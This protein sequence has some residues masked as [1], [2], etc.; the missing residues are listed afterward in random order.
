MMK[1]VRGRDFLESG[2]CH[3]LLLAS[4][5]LKS[6]APESCANVS[7]TFGRGCTSRSTFPFRGF[8]SMHIRSAPSF[9]GT[10]TMPAHHGVGSSAL[11]MTPRDSIRSS[12]SWTLGRRVSGESRSLPLRKFPSPWN[13]VG[14][15]F[16]MSVLVPKVGAG[17]S[18]SVVST[19]MAN[20][21]AV[22]AGRPRRFVL[23]PST[24]FPLFKSFPQNCP[25]VF[26]GFLWS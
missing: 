19:R 2:I 14:N 21:R 24:S 18:V 6:L 10:T 20:P 5:L 4:N 9:S 16:M 1:V 12:S 13:T 8:R 11:E 25:R 7:P 15:R 23:R 22:I 17:K 26:R 3:N